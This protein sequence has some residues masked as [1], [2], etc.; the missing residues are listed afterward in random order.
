[1]R[2]R[3]TLREVLRGKNAVANADLILPK[4]HEPMGPL[5]RCTAGMLI[6]LWTRYSRHFCSGGEGGIRTPGA[7]KG[8]RDFESRRLNLT[9]EPLRPPS[10]SVCLGTVKLDPK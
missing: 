1:M 7:S 6:F 5:V 4:T 9:P 10:I 8:T 2:E 3:V